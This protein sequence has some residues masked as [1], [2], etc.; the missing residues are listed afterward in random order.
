M[1]AGLQCAFRDAVLSGDDRALAPLV[2]APARIAI[3]RNTVQGSLVEVLAAAYPVTQRIVGPGF[4]AGLAHT[5]AVAHP[6]RLPQ[7]STYGADFPGF[8][9]RSLARHGLPY[10]ADVA[11]LEWARGESYFAADAPA[12]S[13]AALAAT[14]PGALDGLKLTLHPATRLIRSAFPIHRIWRVNQP[15][16]T[17]VPAVDMTAAEDV[18]LTRAE[19]RVS[20][21]V[22]APGDAAFIAAVVSGAGLGDAAAR[23]SA[24]NHAFDLES[25]LRDHLIG[26]SFA[27]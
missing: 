26:G 3:Y 9:D 12:L 23:A 8:V 24:E 15:E 5:F 21:R 22:I 6:P 2:A 25:A 18:L 20:L 27:G 14:A 4:F 10:L 11:R 7:L 19:D 17:E 16:V 13:P 1:I